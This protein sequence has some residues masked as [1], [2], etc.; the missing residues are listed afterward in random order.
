MTTFAES[1]IATPMHRMGRKRWRGWLTPRATEASNILGLPT[2]PNRRTTRAGSPLSRLS[3]NTAKQ[4]GRDFRIL[5]GIESD[6]LAD[7]SLDYPDEV[8]VAF[9]FVVAS[10]HGR[11][12]M[13]RKAQTER[14]LRA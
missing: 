7:G 4:F 1:C 12:K 14:L 6:I 13:D 11:V 2:I 3:S 5:K 9:D 8:L 10:I